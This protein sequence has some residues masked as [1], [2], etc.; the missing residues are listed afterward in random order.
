MVMDG[1]VDSSIEMFNYV[2]SNELLSNLGNVLEGMG[3]TANEAR[4]VREPLN[5]SALF[6]PY[7]DFLRFF[8]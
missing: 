5:N 7:P 8:A 2:Q 4:S 3:L 6:C 1:T